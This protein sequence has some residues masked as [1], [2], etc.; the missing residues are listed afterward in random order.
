MASNLI[1][2]IKILRDRTGA[3]MMDCKAALLACDSD[4]EKACEWLREKGIAKAA[5]KSSRIAAEGLTC[6]VAKGDTAV[7]LE[8][9]S[10]TDFV[11]KSDD[12]KALV[13]NVADILLEK[14]PGCVNCA[15][16]ATQELFTNATVKI[17]EKLDLRRFEIVTKNDSQ[18]FG[19][20]IHMGG[21]IS[22]LALLDNAT[23]ELAKGIA[24]SIA[25]N[26]PTYIAKEDIPA[27]IVAKETAVQMEA[28]KND[29]K[30]QGKPEQALVKIVEGKVNKYLSDSVL[31]AQ[32]YLLDPS[33][34]VAN[35]LG[36]AKVVKFV[37]YQV[38]EGLQKREENFAEEVAKQMN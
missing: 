34:K 14:K 26:N 32:E 2:L 4:V 17:G 11:A 33:Q 12:F 3:G 20:Y 21:K 30:L 16:E 31:L 28:A 19:T 24:M 8:V 36:N 10:E 18:T 38:G 23:N 7:I 6:V 35:V 27:E 13:N 5:K 25:A 1:E 37:R 9:N 22:V 15:K 29:P